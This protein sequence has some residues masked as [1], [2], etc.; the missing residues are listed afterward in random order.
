MEVVRKCVFC[1][2]ARVEAY[3][4]TSVGDKG[5]IKV[6]CYVK[7]HNC[8]ARGPAFSGSPLHSESLLDNAVSGWNLA[9]GGAL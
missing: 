7:C 8:R 9:A 6:S 4:K 5:A 3:S 2:S 1:Q